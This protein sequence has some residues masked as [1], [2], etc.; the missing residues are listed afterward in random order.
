MVINRQRAVRVRRAALDA[1]LAR[2]QQLCGLGP[3]SVTVALV[4]PAA[5]ARLNRQFRGKSGPTDVLSFPMTKNGKRDG[6]LGDI[7]IAPAVA[8]RHARRAG[9]RLEE[10]LCVLI[11]HGVLHLLGYDHETDRGEM[12]RLEGRLRRRLGLIRR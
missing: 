12:N 7:A 6:Y 9:H 3:D 10:E 1:F 11:L 2:V 8:R 5:I 4:S